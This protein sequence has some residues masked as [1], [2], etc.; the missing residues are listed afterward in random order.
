MEVY[1]GHFDWI[2]MAEEVS[3]VL[4][5]DVT[6]RKNEDNNKVSFWRK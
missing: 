5:N 6:E 4:L 2:T 3:L 1:P